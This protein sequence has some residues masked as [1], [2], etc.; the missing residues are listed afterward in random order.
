MALQVFNNIANPYNTELFKALRDHGANLRVAYEAEPRDLGRPWALNPAPNERVVRGPV[1]QWRLGRSVAARGGPTVF[2][3][4]FGSP[5]ALARR[6]GLVG[7][8][9]Q[10]LF[11]GERLPE[12]SRRG[13]LWRWYLRPFD[14]VL[15]VGRWAVPGYRKHARPGTPVHCMPYVT[16]PSLI[17]WAPS[18]RPTIG[19]AG[20]LIHRKGLDLVIDALGRLDPAQRPQLE[21]AGSGPDRARLEEASRALGIHVTWLGEL[22]SDE[23]EKARSKWWLQVVPSRYDGWGVVVSEALGAGVPV[24]GSSHSGA[25]L[26]MVRDGFNGEIVR[27]PGQWESALVRWFSDSS[28]LIGAGSNARV[29]GEEFGADRAAT[30]L[31]DLLANEQGLE[32]SFVDLAWRQIVNRSAGDLIG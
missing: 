5:G 18:D 7:A 14:A 2:S 17:P 15:A 12:D 28:A 21:V 4:G 26:D 3:G 24:L 16:R 27:R 23:L 25:V 8:A 11:W 30:W 20:S 19:F 1:A 22:T 6:L 13:A 31:I 9:G 29:V 32:R 10:S